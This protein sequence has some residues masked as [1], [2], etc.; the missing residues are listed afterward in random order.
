MKLLRALLVTVLAVALAATTAYG[1][2]YAVRHDDATASTGTEPVSA[3]TPE[4]PSAQQVVDAEP[5]RPGPVLEPGDRG[6]QVRELQSR[7]FQLDW[8]PELTT[9]SYGEGTG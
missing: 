3:P 4:Q 8:F 1:V 5:V 2:G 9:G 6:V 7:L